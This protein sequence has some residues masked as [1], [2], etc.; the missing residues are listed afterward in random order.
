MNTI[1]YD[2]IIQKLIAFG[3][4]HDSIRAVLL[5]SSLCNPNAPADILSDFDVEVFFED[6]TPFVESDDWVE[7]LGFGPMMALWHWPNEWDEEKSDGSGWTRMVYY[8]DGTKMDISL[9]YL[10]DLRR[11]ASLPS[12]PPGYDIGYRVLLDKDGV[13]ASMQPPTYQAYILT[14]P[15]LDQFRVRQEAF[16]MDSTY[17]ARYLWRDD[18][19]GAKWRL[20]HIQDDGLR[21]VLEWYVAM[22]HGWDWKPGRN[23]RGLQKAL[24]SVTGAE[25]AGCYAGS[26]VNELWGSLFRTTA[27]F[28]KTAIKVA[29]GLGY[30]YDHGLDRRVTIYHETIRRL[31][32]N[33]SREDLA[34]V[35]RVRL[36]E[37]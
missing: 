6:P 7:N 21:E 18:I 20:N 13:T 36:Q 26:T 2:P 34:A 30:E 24:D 5:T 29:E 8:Q 22:G 25:L 10:D 11:V 32:R 27:L 37:S 3:E 9:A 4:R 16:W 19:V 14:P 1:N 28:S 31:G 23:G 33:A 35:L 17:V 15:K 12:L